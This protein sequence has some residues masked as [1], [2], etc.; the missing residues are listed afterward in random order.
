LI[1]IITY[2]FFY[3]L[4]EGI[5]ISVRS[6][7]RSEGDVSEPIKYIYSLIK[8][9]YTL[10]C[11]KRFLLPVTYFPTNLVYPF[12][13]RVT[14]IINAENSSNPMGQTF[15]RNTNMIVMSLVKLSMIHTIY[16]S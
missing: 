2:I 6:L 5:L 9:I 1:I 10:W 14:G 11:R 12:T 13:L 16:K 15:N 8:N 4:A 3:T 7:Q